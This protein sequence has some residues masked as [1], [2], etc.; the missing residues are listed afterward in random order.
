MQI[1]YKILRIE[2]EKAFVESEIEFIKEYLEELWFILEYEN[3]EK[4]EKK[5]FSSY[6]LIVV[7]YNLAEGRFWQDIIQ[8]IRK[9]EF[10]RE[11]LFYSWDGEDALRDLVKHLDWVYC[12]SKDSCGEKLKGLI[13]N[14]IRKTQDIN[15]LRGLIMAETSEI[16]EVIKTIIKEM[17]K[18]NIE[19]CKIKERKDKLNKYYQKCIDAVEKFNLP[20]DF[21]EFIDSKYVSAF[22]AYTTLKSFIGASLSQERKEKLDSYQTEI[23]EPRNNFG[24]TNNINPL[25]ES[26][27]TN[28]RKKIKDYKD[29]FHRCHADFTQ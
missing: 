13:S 16:D 8:L 12:A 21:D 19:E 23:I 2:D 17:A 28:F 7:D 5:D 14:T 15:N 24:H 20:E 27:Y 9:E 22:F 25:Q 26:E 10:Y 1:N 29:F 3:P 6:D 18:T 11:I 4:Y